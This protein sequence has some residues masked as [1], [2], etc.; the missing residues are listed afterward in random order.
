M[1]SRSTGAVF[2]VPSASGIDGTAISV[3]VSR[4]GG[5][6]VSC[7]RRSGVLYFVICNAVYFVKRARHLRFEILRHLNVQYEDHCVLERFR[8]SLIL[9]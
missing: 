9:Q 1:V 5:R 7:I 4:E 8:I 6:R 2:C 3:C